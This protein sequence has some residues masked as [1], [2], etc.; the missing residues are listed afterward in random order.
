MRLR[1]NRIALVQELRVE[2]ILGYLKE[3]GVINEEDQRKIDMG[4]TP[5]DKARRLVDIL[6]T[7]THIQD[8]Y[9]SFKESLLNPE[10]SH[11][12]LSVYPRHD[13]WLH[14]FWPSIEHVIQCKSY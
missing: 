3:C 9:Q 13:C 4:T 14:Y 6:P 11:D 5:S 10:E 12:I 8:W 2:Y 7:K 1:I